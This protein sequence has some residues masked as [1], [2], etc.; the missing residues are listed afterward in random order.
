MKHAQSL[1]SFG[2][3]VAIEVASVL[4]VLL[5]HSG[6]VSQPLRILFSGYLNLL[7]VL[8]VFAALALQ[9]LFVVSIPRN[10]IQTFSLTAVAL[11][12]MIW[13][14]SIAYSDLALW[15]KVFGCLAVLVASGFAFHKMTGVDSF[16]GLLMVRSLAGFDLMQAVAKHHPKFSRGITDFGATMA[17][18]LPWGWRTFGLRK[19]GLHALGLLFLLGILS[20]TPLLLGLRAG[21]ELVV[22]VTL[23]FGFVG[24]GLLSLLSSAYHVATVPG[25]P[26]GVQL[27]IPGVTL[28][29]ESIFAIAVIA[30]VHEVAHGVLAY[31]EKLKLKSSGVVLFGFLPV[32]AFV[33]P[34]EQKLDALPLEKKRR[35]LVAGS[36][37]N[38]LFFV[39]FFFLASAVALLI[40]FFVAGVQV[41]SLPDG[42]FLSGTLSAGA[43]LLSLDDRPV[44]DTRALFSFVNATHNPEAVFES[45]GRTVSAPLMEVVVQTVDSG[46]PAFG[47]LN[48]GDRILAVDGGSISLPSDVSAALSGRGPNE[49][50]VISTVSGDK[51]VLLGTDGKLGITAG[52]SPVAVLENRAK[53]G[54]A[55]I[56]SALSF[57]LV[58]LS[59]TYLLNFLISVV[60][61]LPLFIT[62]GQKMLYYELEAWLGKKRAAHVSTA[63][64]L[65]VLAIVLVNA[66]PFFFG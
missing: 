45:D 60:N 21:L 49:P 54:F 6:I 19:T 2:F 55:S 5:F 13:F 16:F 43:A 56:L 26:A 18:G 53:P 37:S 7:P 11:S 31:V 15:P 24:F 57:L 20:F 25:A 64:G 44:Q 41:A 8:L 34:D 46:H 32:G 3:A 30:I 52:F 28:P 10:R 40:P 23:L 17:F 29:W 42:S 22:A 61:L 36:T 12:A 59:L 66:S 35:I 47:V 62:D 51:A 14:F 65:V 48:E 38:A 1:F 9:V 39:V 33:E 63:A 58:V 50:V 27:L 4:A